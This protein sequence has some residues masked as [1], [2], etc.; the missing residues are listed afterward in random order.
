M[1]SSLH[2]YTYI[3]KFPYDDPPPKFLGPFSLGK[4][5]QYIIQVVTFPIILFAVIPLNFLGKVRY[6]AEEIENATH[7]EELPPARRTVLCVCGAVRGVGGIDSWGSDVEEAYRI[8]AENVIS[9]S[10]AI[11]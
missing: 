1:S 11:C 5:I 6:I 9:Y 7:Y 10:F 8:N 3:E 4:L 2:P